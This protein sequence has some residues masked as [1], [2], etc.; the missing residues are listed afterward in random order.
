MDCWSGGRCIVVAQ[1][2]G[3][4]LKEHVCALLLEAEGAPSEGLHGA[5]RGMVDSMMS[6]IFDLD[7][8]CF[9]DFFKL[10]GTAALGWRSDQ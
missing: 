6:W 10:S 7:E 5:G 1:R 3:E 8:L 4:G 9:Y 2:V